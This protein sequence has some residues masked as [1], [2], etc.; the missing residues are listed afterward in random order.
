MMPAAHEFVEGLNIQK[1][2]VSA[3]FVRELSSR[4]GGDASGTLWLFLEPIIVTLIVVSIHFF[5]GSAFV[6]SVPVIIFLL[7]GYVPHLLFRHGGLSGLTAL[8]ANSG[9]LY[10]PQV[11]FTDIVIARLLV[12]IFTVL[13]AFVAIYL[14]FWLLGQITFPREFAYIYL[15]WFF[16]IWFLVSACFFFTGAGLIWPIVRRLF[17]PLS[18]LMLP[19]YGAFFMLSWIPQSVRD[20]LLYFPTANATE[21]MRYGY[22][23]DSA[24]TYFSLSYTFFSCLVFSAVAVLLLFRG[25]R[26]LEL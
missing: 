14:A 9:L 8:N 24:P 16:H 3:L 22:F 7:T 15:G 10:H 5:G 18:L 1:R 17:M 13:C 11:H 26:R 12:E 2:V 25:R 19:A 20:I 23:G 6:Q 21:I 4:H